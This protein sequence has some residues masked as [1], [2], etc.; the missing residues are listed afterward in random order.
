MAHGHQPDV[1]VAAIERRHVKAVL[2]DLQVAAAVNHLDPCGEEREESLMIWSS[3][4]ANLHYW[5]RDEEGE[6]V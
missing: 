6:G 5:E 2:S 3:H 1:L 4:P